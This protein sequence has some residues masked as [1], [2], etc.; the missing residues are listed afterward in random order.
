M[1]TIFSDIAIRQHI[2]CINIRFSSECSASRSFHRK[3]LKKK[4]YCCLWIEINDYPTCHLCLVLIRFNTHLMILF[5]PWIESEYSTE[6]N[7]SRDLQMVGWANIIL[8]LQRH[9]TPSRSTL[10]NICQLKPMHW[11]SWSIWTMLGLCIY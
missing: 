8:L 7:W 11:A 10:E 4:K 2:P 1:A 9:R 3:D 6:T 5:H